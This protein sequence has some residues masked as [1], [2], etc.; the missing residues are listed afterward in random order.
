MRLRFNGE[1][2]R[3]HTHTHTHSQKNWMT[4]TQ[5]FI[6][7]ELS[8]CAKIIMIIE[9]SERREKPTRLKV[10]DGLVPGPTMIT[11]STR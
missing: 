5:L 3:T 6:W 1:T 9:K 10:M 11:L 4:L 7:N 2:L 8:C